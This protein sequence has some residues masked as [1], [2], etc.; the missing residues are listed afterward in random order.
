MID[1]C[2]TTTM[3][4]TAP[5]L[6]AFLPFI[7]SGQAFIRSFEPNPG[8][9]PDQAS[10]SAT[11]ILEQLGSDVPEVEP[12]LG[13]RFRYGVPRPL[14][15][16]FMEAAEWSTVQEGN[17]LGSLTIMSSGAAS[18]NVFFSTFHLAGSAYVQLRSGGENQMS[19]MYGAQANPWG[20]GKLQTALLPG[21]E[22]VIEF[23]GSPEEKEASSL[24]IGSV[25]HGLVD[26]FN[27]PESA[28]GAYDCLID[29]ACPQGDEWRDEIRSVVMFTREDGQGCS[30][31]LLNN[32]AQDGTPYVYSAHHCRG[33]F[34]PN[35]WV[36]YF[37]FQKP[38]CDGGTATP[39]QAIYGAQLVAEDYP[40]DF[41]L[42]LLQET[43]PASYQP[44]YAGWDRSEAASESGVLIGHPL[45]GPKK[46]TTWSNAT[47]SSFPGF[48]K[49]VWDVNILQGGIVGGSSG[50]PFFNAGKRVIGV[51]QDGDVGCGE[52]VRH[53]GAPQLGANWEG[54][55]P[56]RRLKDWL[57]PSGSGA[58]FLDGMDPANDTD[59]EAGTE[60][61]QVK[62][63][64]CLQGAF[65]PGTG[66]MRAQLNL[67][68]TE[69]Y[70]AA[71]YG[72]VLHGGNESTTTSV[73]QAG[74]NARIVD[75]V[76]VELRKTTYPYEVVA[77]R[78]GLLRR[79]GQVAEM[80]G[81]LSGLLFQDL[82]STT[83]R[84]A[85]R[86]RNHLGIMSNT[87]VDLAAGNLVDFASTGGISIYG[88]QATTLIGNTRCMWMGDVDMNGSVKYTGVDNDRDQILTRLGGAVNTLATGYFA[89]DANLDGV[90]KYTGVDNDR[91]ALWNVMG[92]DPVYERN[93]QL[94]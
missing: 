89:E 81:S 29:A 12:I 45:T 6:L 7:A 80:N 55:Q 33:S 48:G 26:L 19:N 71:G 28:M 85:V 44:Y 8:T 75:W 22:V 78:C 83:Y 82:P 15:I 68:T 41:D 84:V 17:M 36:F 93:A 31:V 42:F 16:N 11:I 72:H 20:Q 10:I 38:T 86:H 64:V 73:L 90:V 18:L 43:P 74:G 34:N 66:L 60:V 59:G 4:I 39:T 30:G 46:I 54:T 1:I 25:V 58:L 63:K 67:P 24:Q 49:P 57:D 13:A 9:V 27:G 79:D 52:G 92:G 50:S 76:V 5:I 40:G 88:S 56:S 23:H 51:A 47:T 53:A 2:R 21:D 37:N 91:D 14:D 65:V 69:P 77:T 70:T 87:A 61:V 32:T 3:R 62:V 94:P 35:S